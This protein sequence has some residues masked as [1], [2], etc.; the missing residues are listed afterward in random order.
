MNRLF[1]AASICGQ[2]AGASRMKIRLALFLAIVIFAG[3]L[4]AQSYYD[5]LEIKPDAT[6]EE[7]IKAYRGSAKKYHPDVTK[8]EKSSAESMMKQIN[9]AYSVLSDSFKRQLYDQQASSG[10][11]I[12]SNATDNQRSSRAG[13]KVDFANTFYFDA[14]KQEFVDRY[15]EL[16]FAY[17]QTEKTWLSTTE[18]G[19]YEFAPIPN[20]GLIRNRVTK[21]CFIPAI[22]KAMGWSF[23]DEN[24]WFP[25]WIY[26]DTLERAGAKKT[27]RIAGATTG[28]PSN[29]ELSATPPDDAKMKVLD[30]LRA[31]HLNMETAAQWLAKPESAREQEGNLFTS[32]AFEIHAM[33]LEPAD[34]R[35]DL[36]SVMKAFASE[37]W[38]DNPMAIYALQILNRLE[39][40]RPSVSSTC[41]GQFN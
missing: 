23:K 11:T 35:Q 31:K 4:W 22:S 21:R 30:E 2:I 15:T 17:S 19:L 26:D 34:K 32:I 27:L 36:T 28:K 40:E 14:E 18:R 5:V 20:R 16:R 33:A 24:A 37:H 7:I 38:I 9:V 13:A 6:Q 3:E 29:Y 8:L 10:E 12:W 1:T 41:R 39:R 25:G